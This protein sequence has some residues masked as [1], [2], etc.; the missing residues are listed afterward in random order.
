MDGKMSFL[1]AL[2]ALFTNVLPGTE[3][4]HSAAAMFFCP[5]VFRVGVTV[6]DPA[7]QTAIAGLLPLPYVLVHVSET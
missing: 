4:K 2:D 7:T 6:T 1:G 3:K 5:G